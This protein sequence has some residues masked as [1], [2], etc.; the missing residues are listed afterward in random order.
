LADT[1][2]LLVGLGNP[3]AQYERTRHNAG[4][5]LLD[6]LARRLGGEFRSERRFSGD[7]ATVRLEGRTVFLLKPTTFMNRSGQAVRALTHFHKLTPQQVLVVHDEIDLPP[8][9]VRLKRDGGHGGHN[10]LRDIIANFG[11]DRDFYRL[12][13]GVGRPAPGAGDVVDFVLNA[14]SA[15]EREAI[16]ASIEAALEVIPLLVRGET[17]RAMQQLHTQ[18]GPGPRASGGGKKN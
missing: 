9:T 4:F 5:W 8:G 1:P 11:G 18:A 3:G 17:E 14:P 15:A 7:M 13:I 16:D 10:G 2:T 12:R 6:I